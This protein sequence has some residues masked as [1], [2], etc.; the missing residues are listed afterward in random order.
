MLIISK[1]SK[2]TFCWCN[3]GALKYS[4][5]QLGNVG[6]S[7]DQWTRSGFLNTGGGVGAGGQGFDPWR[8]THSTKNTFLVRPI[9][10]GEQWDIQICIQHQ[11]NTQTQNL[12]VTKR[13]GYKMAASMLAQTR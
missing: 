1:I 13:V 11:I 9:R 8:A 5:K 2:P 6:F 7:L 12:P 10:Q 3:F 4:L